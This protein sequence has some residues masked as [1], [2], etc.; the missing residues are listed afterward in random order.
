MIA[1]FLQRF[2]ERSSTALVRN[3]LRELEPVFDA[4]APFFAVEVVYNAI[5][6][7]YKENPNELKKLIGEGKDVKAVC[8]MGIAN[9]THGE[10]L[11]GKHHTM[12]PGRL[13]LVGDGMKSIFYISMKELAKVGVCTE[14]IARLRVRELDA[15][16]KDIW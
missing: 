6:T 3:A 9:F 8:L 4:P 1:R 15:A 11:S 14:E 10:L 2:F 13:T 16:L 12:G 7:F 5:M